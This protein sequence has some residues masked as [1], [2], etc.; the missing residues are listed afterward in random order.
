MPPIGPRAAQL[1]FGQK[2]APHLTQAVQTTRGS[3][4]ES[5]TN[6]SVD[7]ASTQI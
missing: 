5:R 3:T 4:S 6:E 1:K 2:S 7:P